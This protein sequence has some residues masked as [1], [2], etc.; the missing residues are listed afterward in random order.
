MFPAATQ[1]GGLANAFPDVC[2]TP[3]PAGPV[4]V[5][6]PN[7]GMLMQVNPV[8]ATKKVR[9]LGQAMLVANSQITITT[10]DEAG[11]A[12]GV[13]SGMIKGPAAPKTYS[14]KV[15]AEGQPV[16]YFTCMFAHNGI[17]ANAPIGMHNVPSQSKVL[18]AP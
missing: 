15:K 1:M 17:S 4:P 7:I 12:M 18:T 13:T 8:T 3:T 10:G 14:F 9:V 6:Y 2:N 5:P 16:V 11:S